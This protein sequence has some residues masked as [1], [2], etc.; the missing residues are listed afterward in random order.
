MRESSSDGPALFYWNA[1]AAFLNSISLGSRGEYQTSSSINPSLIG[2]GTSPSD[3]E[4]SLAGILGHPGYKGNYD[5][6]TQDL[7][8]ATTLQSVTAEAP[9]GSLV[10]HSAGKDGIFLANKQAGKAIPE[11]GGN[12]LHFGYNFFGGQTDDLSESFDDMIFSGGN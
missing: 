5:P 10:L 12:A 1:N 3:L 11:G 9:R 6:D 2:G 4:T 8:D 7:S